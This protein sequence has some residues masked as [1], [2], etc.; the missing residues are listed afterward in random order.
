MGLGALDTL[1]TGANVLTDMG[2][3]VKDTNNKLREVLSSSW[4]KGKRYNKLYQV[5]V[6]LAIGAGTLVE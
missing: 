5:P 4:N 1:K 3:V 6:G 2:T